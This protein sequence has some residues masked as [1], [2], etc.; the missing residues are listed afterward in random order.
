MTTMAKERLPDH[1]LESYGSKRAFRQVKR[2]EL[3]RVLAVLQQLTSGCAYT[4]A[5]EQI[6]DARELLQKAGEAMSAK[7]WGH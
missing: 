4:P 1:M 6:V 2:A 7:N 5:Y 3:K